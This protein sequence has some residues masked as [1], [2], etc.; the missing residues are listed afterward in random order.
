MQEITLSIVGSGGD[1]AVVAGD[2]LAMACAGRGLHVVKTEAYGPQ[3]RGGESSCTVRISAAHTE[4]QA[5]R[6]D[7][8]VVLSWADFAR[9]A[10]EIVLA[11]DAIVFHD[12]N[13]AAPAEIPGPACRAIPIAP[14]TPAPS[15]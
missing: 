3:I 13:D 4:A 9:F 12:A 11:D 8:L 2:I 6:V 14:R 10:N 7:A 1:G 5:D 15:R